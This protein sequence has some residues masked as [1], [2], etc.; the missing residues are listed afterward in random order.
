MIVDATV[1]GQ[2]KGGLECRVG[3]LRAF[4]PFSQVSLYRVD[5]QEQFVGQTFACVVIEAN[6][7]RRN[8]VLS[9]RAMLEREAAEAKQKLWDSLAVG[10]TREGIVR[11][12]RDFGA[13][14][15]LGGVDGL[16]HVSQLSW[17][18]VGHPSEVLQVGQRVRV[19]IEKIDR[20]SGR[21]SLA[22][23]DLSENPW[24]QAARK[25]PASTRVKGTVTKIMEFGALVR[26]EPGISGMVHISELSH[27]RVFRVSDVVQEGQAVETLVL[28]VD[29]DA[30]RMS[31]S[32][33]ALEFR[34]ALQ[35][36][37]K[38]HED[39]DSDADATPAKASSGKR[40]DALKGGLDRP[41]GG[42]KFG[43]RW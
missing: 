19:K 27:R 13:F 2:N 18:R 40:P 15:D 23:R 4:M 31:L 43:L 36:D 26:L 7:Q 30:Q 42:D 16:I 28:S 33:K 9:R 20:T 11:N 34:P 24:S 22:Y 25:Y 6:P 32:L 14:V 10:Q 41:S 8:L 39:D 35:K 21:L 5:G 29:P 37:E 38:T 12:L 1:T 3:S 17:D